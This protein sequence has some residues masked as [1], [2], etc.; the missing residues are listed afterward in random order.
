M[1][2]QI[3]RYYLKII[4]SLFFFLFVCYIFY[5]HN[6]KLINIETE[7]I[8]IEK[9]ESLEYIIINNFKDINSLNLLIYKNS[10]KFYNSFIKNIHYGEFNINNK[11]N[12]INFLSTISKPSNIINKITIIEGWSISELDYELQKSFI[13]YE[14]LN[15]K[16]II[17]DTYFTSGK[18]GFTNFKN[19]LFNFKNELF[20][21]Y[22]DNILFKKFSIDEIMIIGSLIEMEGLG[23]EDKLKIS[24]VIFNRLEKQM[25]L[26]IDATVIYA[27]TK[28]R[29]DFQRKL[30]YLDLKIK[31]P[32]NTYIYKGLPP[33]PISYVGRKTIEIIMENYKTNYL[34]YFYED[35]EK[36]HIFSENYNEHI[37]KLN[38]YRQKK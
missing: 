12:F 13:N 31:D 29:Y 38:E 16:D 4:S 18:E 27:I 5:I 25:K 7:K 35:F 9:G 32:F 14:S 21:G 36:T 20:F 30:T 8:I 37:K 28:G 11:M 19:K 33:E 24:S 3:L 22:Q 34:F 23:F 2:E 6:F 1:E 17:A 15:Y 10:I 26:Q